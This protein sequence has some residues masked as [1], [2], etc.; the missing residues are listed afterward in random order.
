MF[1]VGV[2]KKLVNGAQSMVLSFHGNHVL[3]PT[4]K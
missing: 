1:G 3:E 2:T 4:G